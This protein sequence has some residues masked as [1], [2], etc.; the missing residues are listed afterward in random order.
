[1]IFGTSTISNLPATGL[2]Y[3]RYGSGKIALPVSPS[4][5]IYSQFEHVSGVP[6]PDGVRGV[7]ITKLKILDVLIGQLAQM[8]SKTDPAF[9]AAGPISEERIDAMIDQY[10]TQIR[11]ARAASVRMPYKMAPTAPTGMVFDLVA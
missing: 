7:T 8:K 3:S 5:Y 1:M 4:Q 10:E 11:T 9:S 6:A 2:A